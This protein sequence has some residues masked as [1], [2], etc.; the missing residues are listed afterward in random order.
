MYFNIIS[1][2]YLKVYCTNFQERKG[3]KMCCIN[4]HLIVK[5]WT[6]NKHLL[7]NLVYITII[8]F[9]NKVLFSTNLLIYCFSVEEFVHK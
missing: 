4:T 3:I 7:C 2:N 1:I 9:H 8:H 6:F 5:C